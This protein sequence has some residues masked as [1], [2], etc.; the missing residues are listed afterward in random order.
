MKNDDFHKIKGKE[1]KEAST[2]SRRQQLFKII[3]PIVIIAVGA[4]GASYVKNSGPKA[5]RNRPVKKAALVE[6]VKLHQTNEPVIIRARGKV[7]P[8]REIA[9]KSRVSGEIVKVHP[10]FIEGG[11]LEEGSEILRIDDYDYKLAVI[12]A[13]VNVAKADSELKIEMGRQEVAKRE[14]ELLN[15][16]EPDGSDPELALRR[17][18]LKKVEAELEAAKADLKQAEINLKRTILHAPFNA[19]VRTKNVDVGSHIS[20]QDPV[21]TLAGTDEYRV[22]VS[23]PVD[24][25]KWISFPDN[26]GNKGSK[27]II[28]YGNAKQSNTRTTGHVIKLLSDLEKEGRMARVLVSVKDPLHQKSSKQGTLPLLIDSSV[29]V[30]IEGL[31][32]D[33]IL[34]IP[35]NALREGSRIWVTDENQTLMIREA[36]IIWRDAKTVLLTDTVQDGELLI[37]SDIPAPVEGMPLRLDKQPAG[38]AGGAR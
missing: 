1:K 9:L 30:E 19:V 36:S 25:L 34:K 21:A 23:M 4:A 15:E 20:T 35:R 26:K 7:I 32:V 3:V 24:R 5:S 17:P 13:R 8:A 33:N 29:H 28:R 12:K 22:Q 11:I 31:K 14:W 16:G 6:A 38:R 27:A 18:H 37:L 10:K 2:T